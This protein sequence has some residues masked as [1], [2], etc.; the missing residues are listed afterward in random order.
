MHDDT[1]PPTGPTSRS[2]QYSDAQASGD[3]DRALVDVTVDRR[4]MLQ[5]RDELRWHLV[6]QYHLLKL[7]ART[8]RKAGNGDAARVQ[9]ATAERVAQMIWCL[10]NPRAVQSMLEGAID[11]Q[12]NRHTLDRG[13]PPV[14]DV[15]SKTRDR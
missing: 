1:A 10:L 14:K 2:H 15:D 7:A 8:N 13:L 3:A 11:H 5:I 4:T 12:Q 6:R 9:D